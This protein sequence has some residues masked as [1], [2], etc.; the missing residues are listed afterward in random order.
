M[1]SFYNGFRFIMYIGM[2]TVMQC[3]TVRGWSKLESSSW[4]S[5][6]LTGDDAQVYNGLLP[7]HWNR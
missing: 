6:P 2:G 7:V 1:E 3:L 4:Y 5:F